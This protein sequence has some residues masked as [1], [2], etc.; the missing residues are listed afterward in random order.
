MIYTLVIGWWLLGISSM[1]W[2]TRGQNITWAQL[3]GC[4]TLGLLGPALWLIIGA[5]MFCQ[6]DFWDKPVFRQRKRGNSANPDR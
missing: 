6:A 1:L 3:A 5:V 4:C 2:L